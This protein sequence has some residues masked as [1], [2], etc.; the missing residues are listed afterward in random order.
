[1]S[2]AFSGVGSKFRR[3]NKTSGKWEA[4][5]EVKSISGPTMSREMIDVTSLDSTGGYREF[6]PSFRDGG[7]ITLSIN[8]TYAGYKLL[9]QDFQSDV[10]NNY[11]IYLADGTSI[12]FS[13]YVQDL[14]I[15]VKFDDAV[16]SEITIKVSGL[17]TIDQVSGSGGS[18]V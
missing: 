16:T 12:E 9:K 7:T 15:T 6:I 11:E 4:V 8:F 14:P 13:G 1:M 17:V 10:L 18:G 3:W 2:N 5:A